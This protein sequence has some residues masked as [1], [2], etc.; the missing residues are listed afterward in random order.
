MSSILILSGLSGAGKTVALRAL[1]DSGFYCIDNLPIIFIEQVITELLLKASLSKI[2]ISV[3]IREKKFLDLAHDTILHLKQKHKAQVIFLEA[4]HDVMIRRYKET[5]RP[6]P[7]LSSDKTLSLT[8]AIAQE[9]LLLRPIRDLADIVIDTSTFNP[10]ELR[11]HIMMIYNRET[12]QALDITIISFGFKHGV[13]FS[14]DLLFDVR[15]LKNPYFVEHLRALRGTEKSVFD[16]VIDDDKTQAYLKRLTELLAFVIPEYIKEGKAYLTIGFGCTGG[17]HR[18]PAIAV[19][20]ANWIE[21]TFDLTCN[22]V[23]RECC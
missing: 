7:I 10:H 17:W 4:E 3:D 13:P 16:F 19:W 6:H 21:A 9:I 20:V 11:K 12:S 22:V 5:R 15:F 1:E 18:S 8:D 23:H 14:L 2:A